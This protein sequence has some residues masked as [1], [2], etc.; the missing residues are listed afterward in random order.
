MRVHH[1][2]LRTYTWARTHACACTSMNGHACMQGLEY[3]QANYPMG[4]EMVLGFLSYDLLFFL[5]LDHIYTASEAA[6]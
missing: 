1:V 5:Q 3:Y 6:C 2:H 4:P